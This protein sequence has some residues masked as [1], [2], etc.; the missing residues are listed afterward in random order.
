MISRI[1][2]KAAGYE[3]HSRINI[4]EKLQP[5]LE[6]CNISKLASPP[7]SGAK[8]TSPLSPK[9]PKSPIVL[10]ELGRGKRLKIPRNLNKE[11]EFVDPVGVDNNE[12]NEDTEY[13]ADYDTEE[14]EVIEPEWKPKQKKKNRARKNRPQYQNTLDILWGRFRL[15]LTIIALAINTVCEDLGIN[16]RSKYVSVTRL[17][18]LLKKFDENLL[19]THT[20]NNFGFPDFGKKYIL[21]RIS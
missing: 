5:F 16:D 18:N 19:T 3:T 12:S 15:S 21:K 6:V 13:D 20:E 17:T 7:T 9:R 8:E 4:P 14:E 1:I 10:E 11:F 2:E